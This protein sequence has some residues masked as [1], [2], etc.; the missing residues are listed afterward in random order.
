MTIHFKPDQTWVY[1]GRELRFE[2]HLG[3]G[4]L[5]FLEQRTLTPLLV[6]KDDGV[7]GPPTDDWAMKAYTCGDLVRIPSLKEAAARKLAQSREFDA[8]EIRRKDKF[9]I[10]RRFVVGTLDRLGV[11]ELSDRTLAHKLACI[12]KDA[13]QEVVDLNVRPHPRTVRRWLAERGSPG[14]RPFRQM[15][16]Q[17]GQGKR[18]RRLPTIVLDQMSAF[19]FLYWADR[20]V[21]IADAYARL[22]QTLDKLDAGRDQPL[23]KPSAET[24]RKLVRGLECFDTYKA[25]Y[26]KQLAK[27]RFEGCGEGLRASRFLELGC[28]DHKLLDNVVVIDLKQRLPMGRPWLTAIIDVYTR[29]VVGFVITFEPPSL[30]SAT[31]CIKRANMP[32]L[33]MLGGA[34]RR[35]GLANI[36]GRFDEIIVDNGLEL[37]GNA[38]EDMGA[39][40]GFS[41]RW[42]P[43]RSPTYKAFIERFFR[44]IDDRLLHKL[45]GSTLNPQALRELEID[46]DAD[47]VLTLEQLEALIWELIDLYH[48][49]IH[50][51]IN[52][53]PLQLWEQDEKAYGIDVIADVRQ[54]DKMAGAMAPR[55]RL[56]RAGIEFLGL[57]YHEAGTTS[58]LLNDLAGIAPQRGVGRGARSHN[59]KIKYNPAN[60]GEIHVWNDRRKRYETL[61]CTEP[62]YAEG[63]SKKQHELIQEF[64]AQR[65]EAFSSR[66]DRLRRRAELSQRVEGLIPGRG[67]KNRR[68]IARLAQSPTVQSLVPRGV[69]L[70][71]AA[72][73]D[74]GQA[75]VIE[76]DALAPHRV[77]GG[78]TS[79]RPQ[80]GPKRKPKKRK[81]PH[82]AP[83]VEGDLSFGAFEIT[84][85]K[86]FK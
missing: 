10:L 1:Q 71:L 30:Y 32:K 36:F 62:E 80:R 34:S 63:L 51:G 35:P 14:D 59:V 53:C 83:S 5:H 44:T 16:S 26:G 50:S 22:H 37:V 55:R 52:A 23:P 60:L 79:S 77:D 86:A 4:L 78:A 73:S 39:D 72:T 3:E 47:A 54:L 17:S 61:P 42:A 85:F 65:N 69:V 38:F 8:E 2:R 12:W 33:Q 46:P 29:C 64:A 74:Q 81:P 18:R 27:L 48:Q 43:V 56:T 57:Q 31:E 76:H 49:E 9:A 84:Q 45:P 67:R 13:P 19:A 40:C 25:R 20:S 6:E 11:T 7:R 28:L 41:I 82:Q 15:M 75:H 24:F 66:Q 58:Q 70:A 68:T 21:N